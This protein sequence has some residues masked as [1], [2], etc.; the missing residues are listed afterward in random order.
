MTSA[1]DNQ[2]RIVNDAG[3]EI[4]A[5]TKLPDFMQS[6]AATYNGSTVI[7]GG[8]D[9]VLRVWDGTSGKE[10]AVFGL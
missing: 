7:G 8:E 10:L 1:G 5:I 3:A 9:S 6:T 2:V 4:R